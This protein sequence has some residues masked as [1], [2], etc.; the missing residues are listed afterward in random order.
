MTSTRTT[1]QR[2]DG[3][4]I[5]GKFMSV[6]NAHDKDVLDSALAL[7][8]LECELEWLD[9][10]KPF[11]TYGNLIRGRIIRLGRDEPCM[12][13]NSW[14]FDATEPDETCR[15]CGGVGI[16]SRDPNP[17]WYEPHEVMSVQ[18]ED[19]RIHYECIRVATPE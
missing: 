1:Y 8:Y 18:D 15:R 19:G 9:D 13:C 2:A 5:G 6:L 4:P 3:I 7:D 14:G 10:Q 12:K 17:P 16:Q 11:P